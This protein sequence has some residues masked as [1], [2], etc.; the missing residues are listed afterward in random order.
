VNLPRSRQLCH[1]LYQS[2]QPGDEALFALVEP[3]NG[4]IA[5]CALPALSAATLLRCPWTGVYETVDEGDSE[6]P[7]WKVVSARALLV[8]LHGPL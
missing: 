6:V 4:A 2:C 5:T 1:Q 3:L 8:P 7:R